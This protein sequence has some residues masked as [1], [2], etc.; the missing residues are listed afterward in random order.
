[1]SNNTIVTINEVPKTVTANQNGMTINKTTDF[2]A[3]YIELLMKC[4]LIAY[5]DVAGC[6]VLLPASYAI[7]DYITDTLKK[8]FTE[9]G[10]QN[11]YFPLFVTRQQLET[12]KDHVEG[13]MPEVAIVTHVGNHEITDKKFHLAIRPTSETIIYSTYKNMIR[14][15]KDLPLKFN[16]FCNVVRWEFKDTMPFI[17]SR[18]FLW[19]ETHNCFSNEADAILDVGVMLNM[20][21]T[22]IFQNLLAL[23]TILGVKTEMEKFNGAVST[24][25]IECIIP[26]IGKGVQAATCH[27]LGTIFSQAFGIEFRNKDNELVNVHQTCHGITTRTIGIMLM[28]HSD[29]K[30]LV[31]PPMVATTQVIVV[32]IKARS[33]ED[34]NKVDAYVRHIVLDFKGKGI[35]V[36]VDNNMDETMGAK[37]NK[38]ELAGIPIRLE[39]GIRD[40]NERRVMIFRRDKME[41]K[42]V[43]IIEDLSGYVVNMLQEIHNNLLQIATTKIVNTVAV[44]NNTRDFRQAIK[45]K[46][47]CLLNWCN[48]G[49]CEGKIKNKNAVKSFCIV[50]DV[51]L[52]SELIKCVENLEDKQC[53]FCKKQCV[54]RCLFGKS[55]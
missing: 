55:Y 41:K 29:N 31:L 40:V 53:M 23:P 34:Q 38:Y 51:G 49:E 28:I 32:P 2:S 42:K 12:E 5:T 9:L 24:S 11:T 15:G 16:Q 30:G 47:V 13:F 19:S 43:N 33:E 36:C 3:W 35:R 21:N 52:G 4:K 6:Y 26:G 27:Y 8:N 18:E 1:M 48:T 7:W 50:N 39:I 10:V 54:V 46:K 45:N 17:R 25:T 37:C 20:Y 22:E 14:S 44:V